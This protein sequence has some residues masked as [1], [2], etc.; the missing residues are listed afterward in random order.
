MNLA[1]ST[2]CARI[3]RVKEYIGMRGVAALVGISPATV[4][5][6][7]RYDRLPPPDVMVDDVPGWNE[8]TIQQWQSLNPSTGKSPRRYNARYNRRVD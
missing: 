8:S 2:D 5:S 1:S 7:R 6:Y 4:R 3:G